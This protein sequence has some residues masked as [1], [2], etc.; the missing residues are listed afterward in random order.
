MARDPALLLLNSVLGV[1]WAVFAPAFPW[2]YHWLHKTFDRDGGT[3]DE[4]YYGRRFDIRVQR[5]E[6]TIFTW[7][8]FGFCATNLHWNVSCCSLS[9]SLS[10]S[11]DLR[12][13]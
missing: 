3:W 7:L 10:L 11:L 12:S 8:R 9:L 4:L 5:L 6:T 1:C 13:Q 2:L